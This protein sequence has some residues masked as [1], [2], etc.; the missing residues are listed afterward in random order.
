MIASDVD[1]AAPES[2]YDNWWGADGASADYQL[3]PARGRTFESRVAVELD[4]ML[5]AAVPTIPAVADARWAQH[6]KGAASDT[7]G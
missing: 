2:L 4:G 1:P 7:E 5:A 6:L 3:P